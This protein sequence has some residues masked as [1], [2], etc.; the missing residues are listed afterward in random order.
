MFKHIAENL[1]FGQDQE[2][3]S[4]EQ[5][6]R[7]R[8]K[9]YG[10]LKSVPRGKVTTYKELAKAS[11][12]HPRTVGLLMKNNKDPVSIPCYKVIRSDG[13]IGGY[14]G[15]GGIETKIMLLRKDGINVKNKRIELRKHLHRFSKS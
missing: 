3:K 14:S 4:R 1:P 5:E 2:F 10:F 15:R 8:D 13:S 11:G 7:M 9:V 12:L 6:F